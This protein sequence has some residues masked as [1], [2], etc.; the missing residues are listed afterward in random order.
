MCHRPIAEKVSVGWR[1]EAIKKLGNTDKGEM[2][3]NKDAVYERRERQWCMIVH[4]MWT[5]KEKN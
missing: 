1:E 2:K 4:I 3:L 5:E